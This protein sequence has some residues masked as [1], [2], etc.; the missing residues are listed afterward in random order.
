MLDE[1]F[2]RQEVRRRIRNNPLGL[3]LERYVE[4]LAER[5]HSAYTIHQYVFAVEHFG[6]WRGRRQINQESICR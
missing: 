6:R 4:Y 3:M 5:G 1:V 2:R